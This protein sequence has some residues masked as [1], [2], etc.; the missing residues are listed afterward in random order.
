MSYV[1]D[2]DDD[3]VGC[4]DDDDD[5]DDAAADDDDGA[6]GDDDNDDDDADGGIAIIWCRASWKGEIFSRVS[7]A[8][9]TSMRKICLYCSDHACC[10]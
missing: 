2:D 5:D 4:Y 6:D 7:S 9:R 8:W 10:R 3:D 1:D